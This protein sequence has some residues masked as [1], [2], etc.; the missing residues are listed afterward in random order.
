VVLS[1]LLSQ[2]L[3]RMV[4]AAPALALSTGEWVRGN[5]EH[6]ARLLGHERMLRALHRDPGLSLVMPETR[7]AALAALREVRAA[8]P[9]P[10]P[11]PGHAGDQ[12][13]GAGGAKG[14][15]CSCTATRA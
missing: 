14:G 10:G 13:G 12:G 15:A 6:L 2:E 3:A 1:H 7:E 8:A 9:R 4:V 11:E 5:V